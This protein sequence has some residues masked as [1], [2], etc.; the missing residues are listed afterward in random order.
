MG[1]HFRQRVC[2]AETSGSSENMSK[3]RQKGTKW[4]ND[5]LHFLQESGFP[6]TKRADFSSPLGDLSGLQIVAECKDQRTMAL[7]EWLAQA[8]R[9]SEK[10]GGRPFA[11]FHKRLRKNVAKSYVTMELEQFIHLLK[12]YEEKLHKNSS[13]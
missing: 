4:E 10:V 9:A 11:I 12:A 6:N 8:E 3:S 5:V 13:E 2:S 7:P 1:N